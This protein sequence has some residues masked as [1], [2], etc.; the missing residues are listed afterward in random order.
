MRY[1]EKI[2]A[3]KVIVHAATSSISLVLNYDINAY[4][5]AFIQEE[6]Q[7]GVTACLPFKFLAALDFHFPI[8]PILFKSILPLFM[9]KCSTA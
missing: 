8:F 7:K 4:I 5:P 1:L 2:D 9:T 6:R 3:I